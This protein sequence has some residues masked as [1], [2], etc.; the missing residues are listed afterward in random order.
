MPVC[1]HKTAPIRRCLQVLESQQVAGMAPQ[2]VF[3]RLI[4][5]RFSKIYSSKGRWGLLDQLLLTSAPLQAPAAVVPAQ[6]TG[7]NAAT[8][9]IRRPAV[10]LQQVVQAVQRA[11]ADILG[12]HLGD[13]DS[14]PAGGFD[15]LSAVELASSLGRALGVELPGTLVF[16]YPSVGSMARHVHSLLEQAAGGSGSETA[17]APPVDSNARAVPLEQVVQAVRQAAADVLGEQLG[18]SDSFAAGSFDSLSAVELAS[19]LGRSL[20]VE[21]TS[22]LVYDYPSV[23]AMAQHV[24]SLLAPAQPEGGST[25]TA[26]ALVPAVPAPLVAAGSLTDSLLVSLAVAAWSRWWAARMPS[27]SCPLG[28]GTWRHC[29]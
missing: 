26:G 29:G 22:T 16:D 24:H 11:A 5:Q 20:G 4:A 18:D 17:A 21:L 7:S 8:P 2:M 28:A 13:N 1:D 10:A 3:A 15:S 19:S 27:A 23:S 6:L 25:A 14:F 9:G 12:E